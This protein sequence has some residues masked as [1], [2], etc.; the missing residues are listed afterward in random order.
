VRRAPA[1]LAVII[2]LAVVAAASG[3]VA[4]ILTGSLDVE[5]PLLWFEAPGT[6]GVSVT[7]SDGGTSAV[8]EVNASPRI[9]LERRTAVYYNS[10]D[11][12]PFASGALVNAT[13][14]WF[15]DQQAGAVY[16]DAG[17]QGGSGFGGECVAYVGGL[18]LTSYLARGGRVYV[19]YLT[20]RTPFT[21]TT[22]INDDI[23]SASFYVDAVYIGGPSDPQN[24]SIY[25]VGWLDSTG[26]FRSG[27]TLNS[28]I[29][30]YNATNSTWSLLS[31]AGH[32]ISYTL[33]YYYLAQNVAVLDTS[34]WR[35]AQWNLSYTVNAS[36]PA[37]DRVE[38]LTV[39]IG[40]YLAYASQGFTGYVYY[41]NLLVT[42][43]GE[44][45]LVNVT[46][47]PEGWEAVLLDSNGDVVG[48]A[49]A[50]GNGVASI[51]VWAPRVDLT[52]QPGYRSAYIIPNATIEILDANGDLVVEERF[53]LVLG[54]DVYAFQSFEGAILYVYS[55]STRG[56]EA[57]LAVSDANCSGEGVISLWL[58]SN[59]GNSTPIEVEGSNLIS[60]ATS[61]LEAM[62]R[63]PPWLAYR[64]EL[65]ASTASGF[66]CSIR[67]LFNSTIRGAATFEASYP[68]ELVLSTS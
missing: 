35:A 30:F 41:D 42:V 19:A 1:T 33:E 16:I 14:S 38:P 9:V 11:S 50:G 2:A 53:P 54:G 8:V 57:L 29:Y 7:L 36:I 10:F 40:Y 55:N 37:A 5:G 12:N 28:T 58:E 62:P 52:Q 68:I 65:Y 21:F 27:D 51:P 4:R 45:W 63:E 60:N 15:Y 20:W 23:V 59:E 18:N 32:G 64:V 39:G 24:S 31:L 43:N 44:P 25:T 67:L 66:R 49:T 17:Q 56:P 48:N 3:Y 13:C 47:L 61:P 46:H 6:P 26:Y 34:A 22:L